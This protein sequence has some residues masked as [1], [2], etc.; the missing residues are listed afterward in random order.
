MKGVAA[1]ASKLL[2]LCPTLC[3][4]RD[5]S[6]PGSPSPGFSRQEHWSGLLFPSSWGLP[7]FEIE[8]TF[9]SLAGGFF[10]SETPES[11]S[12]SHS[13]VSYSLQPNGLYSPWNSL[14]Q[15]IG[16]GT[17]SLL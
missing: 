17:L 3:N 8:S 14:G 6:L 12:K 13:V 11:E 9:P 5:G 4:P 10:T 15:N 7:D 1:A 2:Q 16:V